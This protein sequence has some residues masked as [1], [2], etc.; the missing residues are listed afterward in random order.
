MLALLKCAPGGQTK[1]TP[2]GSLRCLKLK[3]NQVAMT[4][5]G[6]VTTLCSWKDTVKV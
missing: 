1:W 6:V 4:G 5:E 2:R 3:Q